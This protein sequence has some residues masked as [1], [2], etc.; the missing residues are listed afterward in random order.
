MNLSRMNREVA[1][2]GNCVVKCFENFMSDYNKFKSDVA[3]DQGVDSGSSNQNQIS[4]M[5]QSITNLSAAVGDLKRSI[6]M[7]NNTRYNS[8]RN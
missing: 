1:D 8:S 7:C 6:E 4:K 5:D 2:H 3:N